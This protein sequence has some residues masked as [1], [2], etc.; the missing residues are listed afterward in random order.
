[1]DLPCRNVGLY[2]DDFKCFKQKFWPY[3]TKC[4]FEKAQR[5]RRL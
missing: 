3:L 4:S 2:V 5:K 1:M